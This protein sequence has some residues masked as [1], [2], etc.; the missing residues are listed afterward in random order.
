M[1]TEFTLEDPGVGPFMHIVAVT[2]P[3]GS[4]VSG[5]QT[6]PVGILASTLP[7][8]YPL[9]HVDI[10]SNTDPTPTRV[11]L[12]AQP[13]CDPNAVLKPTIKVFRV[14]R[15]PP[16]F[17]TVTATVYDTH[18]KSATATA[19]WPTGEEWTG[20]AHYSGTITDECTETD[21]V[22]TTL[23]LV[24]AGNRTFTG[25]ATLTYNASRCGEGQLPTEMNTFPVTGQ[26][27]GGKFHF[28]A[29]AIV[30]F[31]PTVVIVPITGSTAT[32]QFSGSLPYG[33]WTTS[34]N[35]TCKTC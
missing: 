21:V 16:P 24:V 7:P 31:F 23:D 32:A 33:S 29:N 22:N 13:A 3:V 17:Y 26:V 27:I 4:K 12:G 14:P 10:Y 25:T 19:S 28:A 6:I 5:G 8:A 1:H 18:G 15:N 9:S 35:L 20:T 11:E 34:V 2:P 30:L